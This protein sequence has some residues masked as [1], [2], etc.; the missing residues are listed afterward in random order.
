MD[1]I[2][3]GA[4]QP[5]IKP[6]SIDDVPILALTLWSKRYGDYEL[7]R[8]AAQMH[9]AIKQMPDVSEV[10]LIGGAAA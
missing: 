9:D 3:P 10:T 6:R 1:L 5:L 7:R 2:P 8:V 4:S